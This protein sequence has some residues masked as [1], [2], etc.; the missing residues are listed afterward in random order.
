M[1]LPSTLAALDQL[2]ADTPDT[3]PV[4]ATL[5]P[6]DFPEISGVPVRYRSEW[7]MPEDESWIFKFERISARI[8]DGGM[9]ILVGPRGT[10]KTRI[11]VESMRMSP[12][13]LHSMR[14]TTAMGL[15][16]EIR[17]TWAKHNATGVTEADVINEYAEASVLCIDEVQERGHTEWEDRLL[18]HIIDRR[19]GAMLPTV[20][21]ANLLESALLECLG[22]SIISRVQETGG[23]IRMEGASH[24]KQS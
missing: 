6:R 23:L 21:I 1:N 10:G 15:F 8:R 3:E 2:I 22:D 16:L 19:Y 4:V 14:Y 7:E 17:A 11:A 18:T 24:R 12:K 5:P 9:A 20:I 13:Y